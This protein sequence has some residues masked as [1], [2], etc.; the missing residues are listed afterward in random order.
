MYSLTLFLHSWWRWAVMA[1]V[2]V[3]T[4]RAIGGLIGRRPWTDADRRANLLATVSLDI[5]MLLGLLLYL[6]LSPVTIG[7]FGDFGA[8]MRAPAVR[9]WAVEHPSM[10]IVA[11][12]V[13]HVGNVLA[14][15]GGSDLA[16][17]RRGV[18]CFAL[19]LVLLLLAIPW[20]WV[21]NGR[22]LFRFGV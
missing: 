12:V 1:L 17:H 16:R 13:A 22:P 4:L 15:K 3:A 8:A 9:Y 2:L 5:Q 10:A 18:V 21:A 11:L 6:F 14:R 19:V 20:P 7:A